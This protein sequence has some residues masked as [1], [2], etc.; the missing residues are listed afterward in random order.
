MARGSCGK[1]GLCV[2][3]GAVGAFLAA[4]A[5][6]ATTAF[7]RRVHEL[8]HLV[9]SAVSGLCL[10]HLAETC[11]STGWSVKTSSGKLR[12]ERQYKGDALTGRP[13]QKGEDVSETFG[14]Y[15]GIDWG[16]AE[17][18]LCLLAADGTVVGTRVVPHTPEAVHEALGWLRHHTG[19]GPEA[20][21]IGIETP[22]GV[23]VDTVLEQG[24]PVFALNPKQLDRF[25]DRFT[26]AGAKDDRRDA[27][28]IGDGLRTDAR[29]FRR[30]R[31]DDPLIIHLRELTGLVE[32]LQQDETRLTNRLRDQL[33]RVDAP[34][35]VLSPAANEPWLWTLLATAPHPDAWRSLRTQRVTAVLRAHRIRRLTPETV[36]ATL[37]RPQ[38]T[39]APG[40]ADAVGTRIA[41]LIPQLQLVG[42]QRSQTARQID[43]RLEQLAGAPVAEGE[44][45]PHRDAQIL[46][47]L[48]GVG[49]MVSATMLVDATA[50]VRDRDYL[51]LRAYAGTAPVT[52]RSGKRARVVQMRYACKSRLRQA[53]YHWSR[54]SIQHDDGARRYYEQLRARGH[55][56]ARAL[57]SVADRWLRILVAM[58]RTH[59]LYDAARFGQTTPEAA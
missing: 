39:A 40:V 16:T 58:L 56:Y 21:A 23:L 33:Y 37:Q 44:P 14:W 32:D 43:A 13:G 3:Q 46:R 24:F 10:E 34:W 57:R 22:R 5:P 36:L 1:R 54:T 38:L 50:P 30:V 11:A 25:R 9:E 20:I 8:G 48:P 18:H 47:S 28:A 12:H 52:K 4:T 7:D 29:A 26:A 2:F 59:A 55:Q 53:T 41:A 51:R 6:A 35:L 15:V 45:S 49:R 27:Q 19:A 17:H 42:A 31:P